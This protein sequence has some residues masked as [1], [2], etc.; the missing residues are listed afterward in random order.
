MLS[1][2]PYLVLIT[3]VCLV[4]NLYGLRAEGVLRKQFVNLTDIKNERSFTANEADTFDIGPLLL[5]FQEFFF[6]GLIFYTVLQPDYIAELSDPDGDTL[7]DVG[8][9]MAIQ[10]VWFLLQW[11][12]YHWCAALF[13]E[14]GKAMILSRVYYAIYILSAPLTLLVFMA[15]LSGLLM[16]DNSWILLLLIFIIAQIVFILSGIRIFWNGI[17]TICFIFLYLCAFKI[18]PLMMVL[19]KLGN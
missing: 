2:I 17:G 9:C 6:F 15:E 8:L 13:H 5:I 14:G 10:A 3:F 1:F 7:L 16:P 12:L 19:I 18:A 11:V 4:G